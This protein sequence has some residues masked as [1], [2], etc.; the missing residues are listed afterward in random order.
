MADDPRHGIQCRRRIFQ[1]RSGITTTA[2]AGGDNRDCQIPSLLEA[3][4]GDKPDL[5]VLAQLIGGAP[6]SN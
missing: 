5:V 3:L 6:A 2:A 1:R 4:I